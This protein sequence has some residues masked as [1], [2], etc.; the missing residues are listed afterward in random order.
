M[1][2]TPKL[3][4]LIEE[5]SAK[6]HI[7]KFKEFLPQMLTEKSDPIP[8][9]ASEI[10]FTLQKE[11]EFELHLLNYEDLQKELQNPKLQEKI[12]QSLD[13]VAS[14]E[15]DGKHTPLIEEILSNIHTDLQQEQRFVFGIK[16]VQTPSKY[17]V[18][19]LFGEILPINQLQAKLGEEIFH[20]LNNDKTYY[21]ERF[22]QIRDAVSKEIGIT[23]LRLNPV[24]ETSLPPYGVTIVDTV[25]NKTIASFQT[26]ALQQKEDMEHYFMQLHSILI[27]LAQ[28]MKKRQNRIS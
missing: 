9:N 15:D 14:F 11:G 21:I 22:K 25:T 20:F 13:I 6:E 26:V 3:F 18:K 5:K 24:L 17:P 4:R 10:E 28:E 7:E 2:E 23:F 8:L 19:I 27:K 12:F 16:R 1:Q